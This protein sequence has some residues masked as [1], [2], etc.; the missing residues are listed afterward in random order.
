[1]QPILSIRPPL[2]FTMLVILTAA[3]M[4]E[5]GAVADTTIGE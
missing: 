1:M 5:I 4:I 2:I 3:K